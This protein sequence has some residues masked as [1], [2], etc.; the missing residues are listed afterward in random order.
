MLQ[1]GLWHFEE[2][3]LQFH[4]GS[5]GNFSGWARVDGGELAAIYLEHTTDAGFEHSPM[6]PGSYL[7]RH[8]APQIEAALP[9]H[10]EYQRDKPQWWRMAAE[11]E[12]RL[13]L[14]STGRDAGLAEPAVLEA[15]Q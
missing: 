10:I 5:A 7:H 4:G 15:A 14:L 13:F 9:D 3:G 1:D 2:I 6:A 12:Q 8:L 11:F